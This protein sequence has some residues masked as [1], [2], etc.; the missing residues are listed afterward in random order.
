MKLDQE[1]T[2]AIN[3]IPLRIRYL[4]DGGAKDG[5]AKDGGAKNDGAKD[6]GAKN[7]GAKDG[8]AKQTPEFSTLHLSTYCEN[9]TC[10]I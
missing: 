4:G 7:D 6:G 5:G 8:G 9:Y 10:I 2:I 3:K 1:F